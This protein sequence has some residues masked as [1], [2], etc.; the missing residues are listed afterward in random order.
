MPSHENLQTIES[1]QFTAIASL[2][3]LYSLERL[4]R[5]NSR[6]YQGFRNS[7]CVDNSGGPSFGAT[8]VLPRLFF[9]SEKGFK[10]IAQKT[11]CKRLKIHPTQFH[12]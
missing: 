12:Y 2:S 7:S 6:L 5:S 4:S 1:S 8:G 10:K 3:I 11:V 9:R